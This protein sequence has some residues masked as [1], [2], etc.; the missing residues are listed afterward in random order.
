MGKTT[1]FQIP[2]KKSP[3]IANL[4]LFLFRTIIL[5]QSFTSFA[6]LTSFISA[7]FDI[8]VSSEK[9][10]HMKHIKRWLEK[11]LA[12][13]S[14]GRRREDKLSWLECNYMLCV[15]AGM[16]AELLIL[17]CRCSTAEYGKKEKF[18]MCEMHNHCRIIS[19]IPVAFLSFSNF[20]YAMSCD[21]RTHTR[22][23]VWIREVYAHGLSA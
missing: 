23:L 3:S 19:F 11:L 13:A 20:P 16:C 15:C 8:Y 9:D 18:V 17:L 21:L 14:N 4:A 1:F 7:S 6:E 2:K 10:P 12:F 5:N 22:V